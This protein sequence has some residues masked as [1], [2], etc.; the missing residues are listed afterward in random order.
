MSINGQQVQTSESTFST[1]ASSQGVARDKKR[2]KVNR[3]LIEKLNITNINNFYIG[4]SSMNG[5]NSATSSQN[6]NLEIC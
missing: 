4:G 3:V 5:I 6:N 2:K 1:Y